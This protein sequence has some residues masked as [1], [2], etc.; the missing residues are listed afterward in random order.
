[1]TEIFVLKLN[2]KHT[3]DFDFRSDI[4]IKTTTSSAPVYIWNGTFI[5]G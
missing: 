1:M 3:S 4:F 2:F 5:Y